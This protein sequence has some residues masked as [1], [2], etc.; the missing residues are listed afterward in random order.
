MSSVFAN[1]RVI[2][3]KGDGLT[4][5]SGPP[6][7]CKTPS[8]GGP[9]PIPYPNIAKDGDL[10]KGAKKTKIEGNPVALESSNLSTSTGDEAGTAG[11]G[12]MSSKTK[13]KLTFGSSS[14]DVIIEGK[15]AVRFLDVTQHNGNTF[16]TVLVAAG[17][18]GVA[19]GDD[20]IDEED[21]QICGEAKSKHK[22]SPDDDVL[23][24]ADKLRKALKAPGGPFATA[25]VKKPG[26]TTALN[27]GVM[28]GVLSCQCDVKKK[29]AALS[30]PRYDSGQHELAASAFR[31]EAGALGLI[32]V[33]VAPT[34]PPM[35]MTG[36]TPLVGG[37]FGRMTGPQWAETEARL[38]KI[39]AVHG[40]SNP[41][42]TC[43]APKAIQKCLDDGHKPGTLIEIWVGM[44]AG[45]TV[46]ISVVHYLVSDPSTTPPTVSV[47]AGPAT[48]YGDGEAVPSCATCQ[49]TC[50]EMLC[51]LGKPPCP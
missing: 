29:Y 1:G 30:G 21:C 14:P 11:G 40:R 18:V 46:P 32:P 45:A 36:N 4:Q 35:P 26:S 16:N 38:A 19:Y 31:V 33:V 22:L 42:M 3:H 39:E 15:G 23:D 34:V 43:A 25:F 41:P 48:R 13:G 17:K 49:V 27:K 51:R 8:P 5:V 2:L 10:A 50:T 7:V 37:G 24:K 12:I 6:D 44:K 47:E 28:I 20:P 9:V